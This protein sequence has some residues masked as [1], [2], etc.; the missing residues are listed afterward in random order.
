M[1]Q[2]KGLLEQYSS[3]LPMTE[4]TPALSLGEGNTHS[5]VWILFQ[6][7]GEFSCI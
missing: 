5:F 3:Y 2:W 1:N 6:P 4:Q 7:N